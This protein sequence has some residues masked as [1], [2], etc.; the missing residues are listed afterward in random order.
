VFVK[1]MSGCG[2]D[3]TD[4]WVLAHLLCPNTCP[5]KDKHVTSFN[6]F[7]SNLSKQISLVLFTLTHILS[8]FL[9]QVN[10]LVAGGPL[11]EHLVIK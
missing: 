8:Q 6:L 1:Q 10:W 9:V 2:D 4:P 3:G 7:L 5:R 11:S